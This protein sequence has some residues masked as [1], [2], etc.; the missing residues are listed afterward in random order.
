MMTTNALSSAEHHLERILSFINDR[1][2][3]FL[4]FGPGVVKNLNQEEKK[5][6]SKYITNKQA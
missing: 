2:F 6:F 3:F 1:T 5:I 4:D